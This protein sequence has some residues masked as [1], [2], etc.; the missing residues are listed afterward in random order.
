[1]KPDS[2][3]CLTLLVLPYFLSVHRKDPATTKKHM[4]SPCNSG[5]Y[6]C[7]V[8]NRLQQVLTGG[9]GNPGSPGG[10]GYPRSPFKDTQENAKNQ[11]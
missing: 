7:D 3:V 1:M 2:L 5:G 9:P 4:F 11:F 10:P 6:I 8:Q